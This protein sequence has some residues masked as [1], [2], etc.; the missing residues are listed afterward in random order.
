M[1]KKS[2]TTESGDLNYTC[3]DRNSNE[4]VKCVRI[5]WENRTQDEVAALLNTWLLACDYDL[6][7]VPKD[8]TGK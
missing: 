4:D 6:V 3:R 1:A 5:S 7:V 2:T 8:H